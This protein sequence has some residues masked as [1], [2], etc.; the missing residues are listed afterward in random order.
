MGTKCTHCGSTRTLEITGK[1]SDL[2]F[3]RFEFTYPDGKPGTAESDGY[4]PR[5]SALNPDKDGDYLRLDICVQCGHIHGWRA[6]SDGA[7]VRAI[8]A[9]APPAGRVKVPTAAAPRLPAPRA[10]DCITGGRADLRD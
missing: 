1:T 2:C 8:N 10:P 9:E 5:I 3:A 7:I 4:V 6:L